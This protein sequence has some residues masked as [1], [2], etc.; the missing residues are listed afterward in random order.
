MYIF[1]IANQK[2]QG[3][4]RKMEEKIKC[5]DCKSENVQFVGQDYHQCNSC[6]KIF[7]DEELDTSCTRTEICPFCSLNKLTSFERLYQLLR[8][9]KEI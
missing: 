4:K 3:G 5:I 6:G 1:N 8:L 9:R 7:T 2:N